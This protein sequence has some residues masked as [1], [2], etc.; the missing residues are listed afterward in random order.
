VDILQ[1]IACRKT[2]F[3]WLFLAILSTGTIILREYDDIGYN[4]RIEEVYTFVTSFKFSEYNPR[5]FRHFSET[6]AVVQ[7]QNKQSL[8]LKQFSLRL[9]KNFPAKSC[10]YPNFVISL[11]SINNQHFRCRSLSEENASIFLI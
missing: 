2:I 7:S 10:I 1:N 3:R 9:D 4:Y 5:L 6:A 11:K 8:I